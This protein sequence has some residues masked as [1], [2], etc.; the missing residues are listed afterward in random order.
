MR[1]DSRGNDQV[2]ARRV[3]CQGRGGSAGVCLGTI[4]VQS[5][6][7]RKEF[8]IVFPFMETKILRLF[9]VTVCIRD[10]NDPVDDG[11]KSK[12]AKGK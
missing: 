4:I 2:C 1:C 6:L 11:P 12:S 8:H 3:W 9:G 7:Q 10:G 5:F